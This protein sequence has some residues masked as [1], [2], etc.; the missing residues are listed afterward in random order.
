MVFF[1]YVFC[2]GDLIV[3]MVMDVIVKMGFKN[4]ILVFSFLSDCYVLLVEYI[5]QG[6]V[7]CIYIFG[8]CGLLVEEIFCGLLVELVQIYFYG[9]CVYLVQSG[10]LNIDVVFFGVL[11]CDEF[12]NVNGYI[13][14]V[15]CGFFGYVMVDVDNV[16]QVVMFIE[17]LLFY[18]YNL[19]S[20]E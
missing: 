11:F 14:K 16:K 18:L 6:V 10:E 3:N 5:C 2:G 13:G 9:G 17:E 19:V 8:L 7:I 1:Y 15:C 20:I 12:G 4:L